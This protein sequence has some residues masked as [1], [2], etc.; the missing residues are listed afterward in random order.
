MSYT[1]R[2]VLI[3]DS[4]LLVLSLLLLAPRFTGLTWHE[5]LGAAL[6]PPIVLHLF[7]SWTWIV[8]AFRR[9]F[10]REGTRRARVNLILNA[11][12][13]V[14]FILELISGIAISQ[15]ALPWM[16]I[17]TID[18]YAWRGLHNESCTFIR[19]LMALHVAMNWH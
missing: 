16:G 13:F 8:N 4:L 19:L 14:A 11:A 15:A 7:L 12:L 3:L 5:W 1:R 6:I 10:S 9:A 2:F 17:H 18:D